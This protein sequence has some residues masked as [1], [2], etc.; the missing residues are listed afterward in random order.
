MKIFYVAKKL[1]DKLP[2][3]TEGLLEEFQN[4]G[5]KRIR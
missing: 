2:S 5:K 1:K 3:K 4:P